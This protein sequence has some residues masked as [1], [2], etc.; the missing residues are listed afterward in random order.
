MTNSR[1]SL[2]ESFSRYVRNDVT[3]DDCTDR[4]KS[5]EFEL[6]CKL[7]P[8]AVFSVLGGM[9]ENRQHI[10]EGLGDNN[11]VFTSVGEA[12]ENGNVARVA[13]N[14]EFLRLLRT[15]SSEKIDV[16]TAHLLSRWDSFTDGDEVWK[17]NPRALSG[18]C[19]LS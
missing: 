16:A 13:R 19:S 3:I 12:L 6:L 8:R 2:S 4:A 14:G 17:R 11:F 10:E 7:T 1:Q 9:T 5:S 15:L 18:R